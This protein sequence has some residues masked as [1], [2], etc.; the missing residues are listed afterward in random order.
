AAGRAARLAGYPAA[1]EPR[2]GLLAWDSHSVG[3]PGWARNVGGAPRLGPQPGQGSPV[4]V[5]LLAWG[6]PVGDFR[7]VGRPCSVTRLGRGPRLGSFFL[8]GAPGSVERLGR[9][10]RLGFC[11]RWGAPDKES[12]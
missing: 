12:G 1:A 2:P 8:S 4:G 10:P 9:G 5:L 6:A 7:S 3:R 11:R